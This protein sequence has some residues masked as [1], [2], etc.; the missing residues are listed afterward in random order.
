MKNILSILV[1]VLGITATAVSVSYAMGMR[2]QQ[3]VANSSEATAVEVRL[4]KRIDES[5]VNSEKKFD[6]LDAKIDKILEYFI[7]KEGP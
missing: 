4:N 1:A 3:I 2:S 6:K 5:N 7:K